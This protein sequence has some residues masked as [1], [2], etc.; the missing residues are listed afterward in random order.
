VSQRLAEKAAIVTGAASG[1]GKAGAVLFAAQGAEVF[2]A[3]INQDAGR[4]VAEEINAAGFK[5]SFVPLDVRETA[6]VDTMVNTVMERSGRI[7][8]L[9][10][11]VVNARM[12]NQQD[13]RCI[14]LPEDVWLEIVDVVLSGTFRC[15]KAVGRQMIR[16]HSGSIVLTATVD[17]LVGCAGYDAYTAAKG[18]VISMTRSLAAGVAG[19]G[20]RVNA[21]C[22]SFVE[23]EPQR[24]WL[25]EPG[26][27]DAMR[28]LHLLP[29]AQPEDIAQLAVYLACDESSKVTGGIFPVDSGYTAFKAHIDLSTLLG[30]S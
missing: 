8:V 13:R 17:A 16:Q 27:R 19:D 1:I 30:G 4:S 22:P 26:A 5:A 24:E 6:S 29:I 15:C 2:V 14:D 23:T 18:G 7:D 9:F 28:M 3:D 12:V 10:H 11:N 20:V 25:D 21:I